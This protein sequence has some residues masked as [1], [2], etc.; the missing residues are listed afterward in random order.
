MHCSIR[1]SYILFIRQGTHVKLSKNAK[2]SK[3][4]ATVCT[5]CNSDN[6]EIFDADKFNSSTLIFKLQL[7]SISVHT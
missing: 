7:H 4:Y 3:Y 5:V 6:I 2:L 1:V